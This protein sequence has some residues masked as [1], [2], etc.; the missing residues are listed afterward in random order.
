MGSLDPRVDG[1]VDDSIDHSSG[2]R[3][4]QNDDRAVALVGMG[5]LSEDSSI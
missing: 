5:G 3:Q 4:A 2:V 1:P